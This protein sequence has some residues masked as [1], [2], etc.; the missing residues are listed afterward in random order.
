[1]FALKNFFSSIPDDYFQSMKSS[2]KKIHPTLRDRILFNFDKDPAAY[3]TLFATTPFRTMTGQQLTLLNNYT[4]LMERIYTLK[5]SLNASGSLI[6]SDNIDAFH[7]IRLYLQGYYYY[8]YPEK[9]LS[10]LDKVNQTLYAY[11][12]NSKYL[13]DKI[14]KLLESINLEI[15]KINKSKYEKNIIPFVDTPE[16]QWYT[17][18]I[19][20]VKKSG[21]ISGYK[22]DKN[23]LTGYFGP[24][25][26]VKLSEALKI[27]MSVFNTELDRQTIPQ[28]VLSQNHWVREY[29]ATA[30]KLGLT[31]AKNP[32]ENPNRSLQRGELVRIILEIKKIA[33]DKNI[34]NPFTDLDKSNEN[35]GYILKAYQLKIIKGDSKNN[36]VRPYDYINRAEAVKVILLAK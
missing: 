20:E 6:S 29:F 34:S 4:D 32:T 15:N 30:E 18:Y 3:Q 23:N 1:V 33:P 13:E 8:D 2:F 24:T 9:L 25:D 31:I 22:D 28:N 11:R 7:K 10:S 12:K 17:A 5:E 26:E 36:T 27:T 16:E 14:P 19:S 35:Y 21:L